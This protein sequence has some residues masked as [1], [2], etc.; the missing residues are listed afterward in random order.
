MGIAQVCLIRWGPIQRHIWFECGSERIER[1]VE[2]MF[3][4]T[5]APPDEASAASARRGLGAFVAH[6]MRVYVGA[7]TRRVEGNHCFTSR[8]PQ[9]C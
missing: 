7:R 4:C 9:G 6:A 1:L 2:G 8:H 3:T 5:S